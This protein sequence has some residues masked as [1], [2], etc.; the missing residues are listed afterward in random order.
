MRRE[1]SG[2]CIFFKRDILR[3]TG[4]LDEN[5]IF[6]CA[7]NDYSNTLW[8]LRL[9]HVLVTSSIVDHLENRTLKNQ[10][11][12]RQEELTEDETVYYDKK[13]KSRIGNGWVL[14]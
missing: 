5:Y 7:D 14:L 10:T 6:W 1:V 4:K 11:P 3:L 2:W 13:W 8:M 9:N 12:K